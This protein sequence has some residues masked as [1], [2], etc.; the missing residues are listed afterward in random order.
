[1]PL[2]PLIYRFCQQLALAGGLF[3]AFDERQQ[4]FCRCSGE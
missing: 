4:R 2:L 1:L 3:G